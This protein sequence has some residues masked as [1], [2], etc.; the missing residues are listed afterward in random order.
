MYSLYCRKSLSVTILQYIKSK[1]E[2]N[3]YSD[4]GISQHDWCE[5]SFVLLICYFQKSGLQKKR[6]GYIK[7]NKNAVETFQSY[8]GW[9]RAI[10]SIFMGGSLCDPLFQ[11]FKANNSFRIRTRGNKR[12]KK[13]KKES[14]ITNQL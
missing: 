10:M 12:K 7:S 5:I 4:K 8:A 9:Y 11:N 1:Q 3:T 6:R 2:F 13:Q 14:F